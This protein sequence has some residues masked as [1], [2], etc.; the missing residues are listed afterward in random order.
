MSMGLTGTLHTVSSVLATLHANH[1]TNNCGNSDPLLALPFRAESR[2]IGMY[3]ELGPRLLV[4]QISSA[5]W[6]SPKETFPA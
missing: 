2:D 6:E 3:T 5:M 1:P 4:S